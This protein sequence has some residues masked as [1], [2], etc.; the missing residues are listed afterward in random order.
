MR[1]LSVATALAVGAIQLASA[2]QRVPPG[3]LYRGPV[4]QS[5]PA[6]VV[7]PDRGLPVEF[8]RA[9]YSPGSGALPGLNAAAP[10]LNAS[11]RSR[12]LRT[13]PVSGITLRLAF[14]PTAHGMVTFRM[15]AQTEP[16]GPPS[17][18]RLLPNGPPRGVVFRIA[19]E[20]AEP[21]PLA[22]TPD[23]RIVFTLERIESEE[24]P[25]IF[26]NPDATE[27]LWEALGRP[28]LSQQ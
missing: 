16:A 27:L 14:G 26:E 24:G 3:H 25:P 20:D 10:R 23:M 7:E 13:I 15:R 1:L 17:F 28:T 9:M 5:R 2:Q 6:M 22:L 19:G 11:V 18:A 8:A 4:Y 12:S 21:G